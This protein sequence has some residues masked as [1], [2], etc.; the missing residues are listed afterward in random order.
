MKRSLVITCAALTMTAALALPNAARA[1]TPF[2]IQVGV[3][4]ASFNYQNGYFPGGG[5]GGGFY[6]GSSWGYGG[7]YGGYGG[8]GFNNA[9]YG[10]GFP[11]F[12]G[13]HGRRAIVIPQQG[14]WTPGR[15]Y[16]THGTVVV[17]HRG[18]YDAYRY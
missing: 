10:G 2:R 1:Q 8:Y 13:G 16:H 17:P 9:Y 5:Y 4:P 11:S 14:H 18:H 7:G 3:G 12:H 15:G 6:P